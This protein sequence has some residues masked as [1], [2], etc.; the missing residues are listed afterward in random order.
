MKIYVY[1]KKAKITY[2]NLI[3]EILVEFT[4]QHN[5]GSILLLTDGNFCRNGSNVGGYFVWS[6]MDNFEWQDG[7]TKRFGLFYVDFNNGFTR[8]PKSSVAW[9]K[10]FL[11]RHERNDHCS[12]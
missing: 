9:F 3:S 5:I 4:K 11:Q 10:N 1:G 8:I 2:Y 12:S 6:F 7:V